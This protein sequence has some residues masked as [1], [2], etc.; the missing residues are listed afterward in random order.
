MIFEVVT[1][2]GTVLVRA[3]CL[4]RAVDFIDPDVEII[5]VN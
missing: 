3:H 1:E 5:E 4:G 2:E